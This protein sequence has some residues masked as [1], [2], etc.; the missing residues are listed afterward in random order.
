MIASPAISLTHLCPPPG[1]R[2]VVVGGCGGIG[3][4]VVSAAVAAGLSVAVLDLAASIQ[5]HH[6]PEGVQALAVDASSDESVAAA[7]QKIDGVDCLINLCGF[8]VEQ[9]PVGQL[10]PAQWDE[11]I[12]G[13]LRSAYL[14]SHH[15][16]KVMTA[17]TIVHIS[18]GLGVYGG[19]TY[20]PYAAAKG[21]INALTKTIAREYAPRIRANAVAPSYVETAFGKGGTGRSD[22]DQAE[23]VNREAYLRNIPMGRLAMP[24]DIVGPIL[25]LA[26]PASGY[27]T[28]QVLHVNGGSFMP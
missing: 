14:V 18:S 12:A 22:E 9:K 8:K 27:M 25:F 16:L 5:K 17:G 3:R 21:G 13:N 1:T 4:A 7:F 15:A 24:E 10:G 2:I 6:V 23:T 11:G 28:G 19:V 20:G 26:G